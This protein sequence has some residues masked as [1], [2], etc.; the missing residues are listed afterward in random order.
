MKSW[1]CIYTKPKQEDLVCK[2]L[3]ELPDIE[4][5][6]PKLKARKYVRSRLTEVVEEL[7]PS[8][9]FSKFNPYRYFHMIKYTRGVK[10]FVGDCTGT[11]YVVDEQII[12]VIR[13]K[14]SDGFVRLDVSE[15]RQG[16][17]VMITEGPFSGLT[18]L[19]LNETKPNERVMILLNA[20]QY[21]LKV[22]V[23]RGFVAKVRT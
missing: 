5:F 1:Y 15:M 2:R 11:P 10:R 17:E 3:M 23:D 7:F 13:S 14:M 19:F 6:N 9:V 12:E 4:L 16:E 21:Q 22:E 18:G 20:I 8:Y